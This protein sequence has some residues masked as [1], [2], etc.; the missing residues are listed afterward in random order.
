L[1]P[2]RWQEISRIFN[3]AISLDAGAR[4]EYVKEKCGA[5][6]DLKAEVERLIESHRGAEGDDFIGGL[7]VEDAAEH[8]S[9]DE[10]TLALQKD[11]ARAVWARF[12]SRKT[13]GWTASSR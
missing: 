2:E 1:K 10:E 13:R 5:D 6:N 8:F 9:G 4:S 12:I 7:A 3:R 11:Q